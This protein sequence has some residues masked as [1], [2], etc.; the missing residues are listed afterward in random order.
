M[1]GADAFSQHGG[2]RKSP[3]N[4]ENG[5]WVVCL[6][7][8]PDSRPKPLE[9]AKKIGVLDL[10]RPTDSTLIPLAMVSVAAHRHHSTRQHGGLEGMGGAN[11]QMGTH[12]QQRGD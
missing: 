7:K 3:S 2:V 10:K 12:G 5:A 9:M 11:W 6:L 4:L 1:S 8:G